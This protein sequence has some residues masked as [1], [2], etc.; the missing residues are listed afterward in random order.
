M[1]ATGQSTS[2]L[3]A[4]KLQKAIAKQEAALKKKLGCERVNFKV[5]VQGGKV[6][7]KAAAG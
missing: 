3:T 7:L 4:A 5:V 1:L 6:R 2:G